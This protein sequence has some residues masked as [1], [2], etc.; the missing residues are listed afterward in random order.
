M[1]FLIVLICGDFWENI[2]PS[3]PF[4]GDLLGFLVVL[5]SKIC[6]NDQIG[7]FWKHFVHFYLKK[8]KNEHIF[9]L[10]QLIVIFK[11]IKLLHW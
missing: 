11:R 1:H 8:N 5:V 10:F 6:E 2:S 3:M 9:L 7:D 4:I